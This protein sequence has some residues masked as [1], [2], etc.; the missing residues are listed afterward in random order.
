MLRQQLN[1]EMERDSCHW[2]EEMIK[3]EF[4]CNFYK[5]SKYYEAGIILIHQNSIEQ[6]DKK[7]AD[8][9]QYSQVHLSIPS[10]QN[11]TADQRVV[12]VM[13]KYRLKKSRFK[14]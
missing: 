12:G 6:Q 11:N 13:L 4:I 9:N 3:S 10:P 2:I 7:E 1:Y 8:R 14:C 5:L